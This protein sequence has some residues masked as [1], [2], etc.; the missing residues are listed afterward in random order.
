MEYNA[1]KCMQLEIMRMI[2]KIKIAGR[3]KKRDLNPNLK[4]TA[5][6]TNKE[7]IIQETKSYLNA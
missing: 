4:G 3:R 5:V 2:N 1:T 6:N 7:T